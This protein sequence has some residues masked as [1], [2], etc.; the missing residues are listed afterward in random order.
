[1]LHGSPGTGKT[2]LAKAVANETNAHFIHLDSPSTMCVGGE[3]EI[4]T[5]PKGR[6][7]ISEMFKEAEESGEVIVQDKFKKII[8]PKEETK[9]FAMNDNFEI[10]TDKVK[11]LLKMEADETYEIKTKK[12]GNFK[13]S[14]NQP[15]ATLSNSGDVMWKRAEDLS[16]GDYVAIA[17]E[18]KPKENNPIINWFD[19][20][21]KS[22][23]YTEVNGK[24][25][26]LMN[27][28]Q[29][30]ITTLRYVTLPQNIKLAK[31][32]FP[33][34]EITPNFMEFIGAIY[35]DGW[36]SDDHVGIADEKP[37]FRVRYK[38]LFMKLFGIP[39]NRIADKMDK[40][41]VYSTALTNYLNQ[42]FDIIRGKK[43]LDIKLPA[44][45]LKC[46]KECIA[47]FLRGYYHG[48]GCEGW[49]KS[50]Y[51]SPVFYSKNREFLKDIQLLLL[52]LGIISKIEYHKNEYGDMWKTVILDTEGRERFNEYIISNFK[53]DITRNWLINRIRKGS[54][55]KLPNI[56]LLLK[57]LKEKL[58]VVYNV[59]LDEESTERYISGRDKL[60]FRKG[61]YILEHFKNRKQELE[62][63]Y[64]KFK[65][66]KNKYLTESKEELKSL[67]KLANIKEGHFTNKS[68]F[69]LV[70]EYIKGKGKL[71]EQR[72]NKIMG[73]L[74]PFF[75]VIKDYELNEN[76]NKLESLLSGKIKWD[77]VT[78]IN[79]SGASTLYDFTMET[80]GNFLG[81]NP[82]T[83]LHNSKYVG[84]AEKKIRDIFDEAEKNA[85]SIIFIDEIDAIAS[86]R[87][88]SY[89]EVE[90]RVVAQLLSV[91]DGLKSRG[92]VVVIAATNRPNS[93]D[94]ALRRPGRF[95]R[96]VE[97]GVPKFEGRLQILKIHTRNMPLKQDV[98]LKEI[99]RITHGY[100]G[101]D[102]EVLCKEAA[103]VV[104]RKLLPDLK[105]EK[106]EAIPQEFLERL[107]LGMED[108]KDALKMVRPSALREV[109]IE[110]P[111]IT[112]EDIGGL[113]NIKQEIKEAVEWPLKHPESF[114]RLGI[115]APKGIL[116]YGPPGTGKTLLAKASANESEANFILV[117]GPELLSKWVGDSEKGV[118][119]IFEKA[120]QASPCIIFFDEIDAIAS[121]RG[122][123]SDSGVTERMV[124]Q[125]LTEID[126]LQE[127]NDVIIM[128]ATNRPDIV[129]PALLRP[130]RFDR[131]I[132]TP[133]PDDKSRLGILQIHTKGMPLA[134]DVD[135]NIL[136]E[137][138]QNFVG[139]DIQSLCREAAILSL[140]DDMNSEIVSMKYFEEALQKVRPS[141]TQEDI[142]RYETI[143]EEY[144]RTARGAAIREKDTTSYFG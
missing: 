120:R 101:A 109:F 125:L 64:E 19:K 71:T 68:E 24:D 6:R 27:I 72:K 80:Y 29:E 83:V 52:N 28:N 36:L 91:M 84:E 73:I 111:T 94:T 124:N 108:F 78:K 127:L 3:T 4:F 11:S 17:G 112:W 106:D 59:N 142:K 115:K 43:P 77:V 86:K 53:K 81:G 88:E 143:E 116:L 34:K 65:D 51:P 45:I 113:D 42:G 20:I 136:A 55:E 23:F 98:D 90:K 32:I 1:M 12:K 16:A 9:V 18:I 22:K 40:I 31:N 117:N 76:L 87:E 128:G 49:S 33:I 110:K 118:R 5:N 21:D 69:N 44:W 25:V 13:T 70:K 62:R 48:D 85:P 89:G 63:A 56:S 15:F 121:R 57:N 35:S 137:K 46:N 97:I 38:F 135:L 130:G 100:V 122:R 58:R 126:G 41:L 138:T 105:Y 8:V 95:D 134:E 102:I 66:I 144:L 39:E 139:A 2:L 140:R 93:I 61:R 54:M 60:T 133:T 129:D 67:V 114:K 47:A 92:K 37:E 82:L 123:N 103:M 99:A 96:E 141:I 14:K 26:S 7:K 10:V 107:Q 79:R 104:L 30:S 131:I 74:E 75:M 119:K 50:K 132:F